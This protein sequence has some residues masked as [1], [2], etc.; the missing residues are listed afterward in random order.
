M[1]TFNIFA[2]G[3]SWGK[4]EAETAEEAIQKAADEVGTEGN[5][6]DLIAEEVEA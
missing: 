4:W 2:N 6:D 3:I 1:T 5:T